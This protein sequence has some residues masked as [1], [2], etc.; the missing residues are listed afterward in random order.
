M[1]SDF[2]MLAG[3]VADYI[4]AVQPQLERLSELEKRAR[5]E[6]SSRARFVKRAT[7]AFNSLSDAGL[8]SKGDVGPMVDK[9]AEDRSN[10]WD[11]VEKLASAL[12]PSQLGSR[13]SEKATAAPADPWASVFGGYRDAGSGMID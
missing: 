7:E 2:D 8:L 4:G 11:F 9:V 13:S 3:Q 6:E 5:D 12:G 10:V 1:D